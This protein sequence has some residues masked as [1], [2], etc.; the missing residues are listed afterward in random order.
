MGHFQNLCSYHGPFA[1]KESSHD[2]N[3]CVNRLKNYLKADK[4]NGKIISDI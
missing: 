3:L 2:M 1:A 4:N